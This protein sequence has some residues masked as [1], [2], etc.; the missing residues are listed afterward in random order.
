MLTVQER[1]SL[2]AITMRIRQCCCPVCSLTHIIPQRSGLRR[3][4]K[5]ARTTQ[6]TQ[7]RHWGLLFTGAHF[8]GI[9]DGREWELGNLWLRLEKDKQH[10]DLIRIGD[11]LSCEHRWSPDW[12]LAYTDHSDVSVQIESLRSVH[13]RSAMDHADV[14]AQIETVRSPPARST[15]MWARIINPFMLRADCAC[16]QDM[17]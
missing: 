16:G 10:C 8:L 1:S 9:L 7:P 6:R 11:V 12:M 13:A 17:S 3:N 14:G 5:K 4:R 15:P 2:I